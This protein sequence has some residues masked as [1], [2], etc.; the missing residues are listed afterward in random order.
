MTLQSCCSI[1]PPLLPICGV[2]HSGPGTLKALGAEQQLA[3]LRETLHSL[4]ASLLVNNDVL[5]HYVAHEAQHIPFSTYLQAS[6]QQPVRG[7]SAGSGGSA[8]LAAGVP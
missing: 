2:T 4:A 3:P 6:S 7:L 1:R 8:W 5:Q